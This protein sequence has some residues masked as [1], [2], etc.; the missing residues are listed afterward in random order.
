MVQ[1]RKAKRNSLNKRTFGMVAVTCVLTFTAL[2]ILLPF[3]N[4]IVISFESPQAYMLHP[5]SLYPVEFSLK[6]YSYLLEKGQIGIG[7]V[8]TIFITVTG[9]VYGMLISVMTAYAFSRRRFPGKKALFMLMMF[10]MFFSGGMVPMYLQLKGMRLID[11]LWGVI[12]P[13]GVS[14]YNIIILKS[15]FEQTPI[16]LE[17]AAKI[18]GANDLVI[19]V[20]IMLPLQGALLA[21]FTLF[22]AVAYWNEWFWSMLLI[23]TGSK[24]TLQTVLRAIICEA[25]VD[26][27]INSG[28]AATEVFSQGVKMAAVIMT[29]L[30]I[31]CFYPFLQKYFVKGVSVGAVKM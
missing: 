25:A 4:C 8:N 3:Y 15:G 23:N 13:L 10:T 17:E 26:S 16:E 9:T 2:L 20:R 21:T 1:A 28:D 12:L 18:D 30:P 11:T 31:M 19:F 29:M 6:N 22:T 24:M 14:T 5:V 7:Y 27:D